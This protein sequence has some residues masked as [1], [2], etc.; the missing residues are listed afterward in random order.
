MKTDQ[1]VAV[2]STKPARNLVRT[3]AVASLIAGGRSAMAY[4]LH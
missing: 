4:A 1:L 3:G 2:P